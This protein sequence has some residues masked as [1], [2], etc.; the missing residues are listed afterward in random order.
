M[1]CLFVC[2]YA[3][4]LQ[5]LLVS[6][7]CNPNNLPGDYKVASPLHISVSGGNEDCIQLLLDAGANVN[8]IFM[9]EEVCKCAWQK[10]FRHIWM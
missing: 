5:Y 9:P 4:V 7:G 10:K 1:T 8:P 6:A 2:T 3:D